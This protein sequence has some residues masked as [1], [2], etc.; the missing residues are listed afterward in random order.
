MAW[1]GSDGNRGTAQSARA[2]TSR[3]TA[4]ISRCG[5]A[6]GLL[7]VVTAAIVI[8]V[9]TSKNKT[10]SPP[11]TQTAE[12]PEK[13]LKIPVRPKREIPKQTEVAKE[14][15]PQKVGEIRDGKMLLQ[16]GRLHP[17]KGIIT[18]KPE[19][20]WSSIFPH[21]SE[22]VIAGLLVAEPGQAFV[23]TPHY[24]GRFTKNFLKS[25]EEP[26][27]V[28]KDDPEDIQ[29]LKRAVIEAK[30]QMK[31]A[32]DRGE[33]I[34]QIL[35]E[36][37]EDLQRMARYKQELKADIYEYANKTEGITDQDVDDYIAAANK[38][39]ESKGIAPMKKTWLTGIKLR[40]N[41]HE[42]ESR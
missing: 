24:N 5:L 27:I 21:P 31:E 38:L 20:A 40:M 4:K 23:G 1:N 41:K 35:Q 34:E 32:Y 42:E 33:D 10:S 2:G 25:L 13:Q 9:A 36:A 22:N 37:R 17:V 12:R 15:A 7:A 14:P 19:R 30:I 28:S 26:I 8:A 6:I 11:K 29:Q 39:L 16:S 18:N 3:K